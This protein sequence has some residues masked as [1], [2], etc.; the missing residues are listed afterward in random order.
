M[1]NPRDWGDLKKKTLQRT[2]KGAPKALRGHDSLV[3]LQSGILSMF[4]NLTGPTALEERNRAPFGKIMGNLT[5]IV[6]EL[7]GKEVNQASLPKL[8][9]LINRTMNDAEHHLTYDFLTINFHLLRHLADQIQ[10]HGPMGEAWMFALEAA[11]GLNKLPKKNPSVLVGSVAFMLGRRSMMA[12]I[13]EGMVMFLRGVGR[14]NTPLPAPLGCPPMN[15]QVLGV[16]KPH[17]L[18]DEEL[19]LILKWMD[20]QDAFEPHRRFAAKHATFCNG[21]M[22][23]NELMRRESAGAHRVRVPIISPPNILDPIWLGECLCS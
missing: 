9:N 1:K 3:L 11:F 19:P 23:T 7:T 22:R 12:R 17:D 4:A 13:I 14:E 20:Q 6:R 5:V 21:W 8:K 10:E 15:V 2:A 16:G 18:D